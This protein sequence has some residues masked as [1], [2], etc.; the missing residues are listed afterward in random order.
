[1]LV[2][3]I[4]AV[5]AVAAAGLLIGHAIGLP[6]IPAYLLVGVLTGPGVLGWIS[7]SPTLDHLS[8]IGVALLLFGVGIEFSLDRLRRRLWQMMATGALQ[9]AL[10]VGIA[11]VVFRGLGVSWPTGIFLGFLASLSST[12]IV[13]KLYS[14]EGQ[15]D[16]PQGQAAA[17]ILLFQDLALVPMMMLVPVLASPGEDGLGAAGTAVGEALL[18]VTLVLF[19]ARVALPRILEGIARV[20]LPELFPIAALVLAFGTAVAATRLGLSLPIGTFLAGLA[21]S[22]SRY[23][24][25]VF[26]EVLPLR[27]AFVALFFTS[28]GMFLH[29]AAAIAEPRLLLIMLGVVVLKAALV[30]AVVR[31]V[32][33]S[34]RLGVMAAFALAQIGEF[35][36]VLSRAGTEHGLL[37]EAYE[38][39]F[40]GTAILTMAATPFLMRLAHRLTA[41]GERDE[42]KREGEMRDHVL[43][44]GYG[45]TGQAIS[46]VL[47]R[48]GIR[49]CAIDFAADVVR[50]ARR[51]GL[52]VRFGDATRRAALDQ[53][54]AALARAAVVTL[55]EPGATRRSVSLLRQLNPD[56]RI[57]V[58]AQRV[59]EIAELERLGAD[60]VIPSEFETSI[61]L[62]V[63]LLTHLGVPRH[64]ARI[65]E[66]LIRQD[67][68]HALR[69]V[70]ASPETLDDIRRL[71]AGGTLQTAEVMEGS[72]ACGQ[73]LGDLNFS[74]RTGATILTIVRQDRPLATI[75]GD[76]QLQAADLLVVHGSHEAVDKALRVLEPPQAHH[77]H[78]GTDT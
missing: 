45:T 73:T 22:G 50:Q 74:R 17:G 10:T 38:Q 77:P 28:I 2:G 48:T 53:L 5:L 23:G 29:P 66:S 61:E 39:V 32:W 8:E 72:E 3:E 57:M 34:A 6:A 33:Q 25:Q 24:H 21:L 30:G 19:V 40:L 14:D 70:A 41:A 1:M 18:A 64:V 20:R 78:P 55:G 51:E 52:P 12:A 37:P 43:V 36:F 47:R 69:G 65:E 26:A 31:V 7:H 46:R 35:S 16:G 15:I 68:Y 71:I 63:R 4:I 9:V 60:E 49:F 54:D 76:T 27:D 56:V 44:I 67:H 42:G 11:T 59:A 58:R 13:F 62:F 75:A